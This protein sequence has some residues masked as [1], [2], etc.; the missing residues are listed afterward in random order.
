LVEEEGI[1]WNIKRWIPNT[2]QKRAG[3]PRDEHQQRTLVPHDADN[4]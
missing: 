2:G 1:H 4:T 3:G